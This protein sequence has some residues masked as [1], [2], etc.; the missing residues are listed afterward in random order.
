MRKSPK[1]NEKELEAVKEESEKENKD[2][3]KENK[4]QK[5]TEEEVADGIDSESKENKTSENEDMSK[6]TDIFTF[7]VRILL[8][9]NIFF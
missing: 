2:L 6:G 3:E 4:K 9:V 5:E 1:E 8:C 7:N